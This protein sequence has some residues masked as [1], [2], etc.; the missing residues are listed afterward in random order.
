MNLSSAN[1]FKINFFK[2]KIF[3][4]TIRVSNA[5]DPDQ[6]RHFVGPDLGPNCLQR[7]TIKVSASKERVLKSVFIIY[8]LLCTYMIR[9]QYS[10]DIKNPQFYFNTLVLLCIIHRFR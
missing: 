1:F 2:K 3:R 4:N 6:D 7:L 8:L 10:R 5:L 9:S